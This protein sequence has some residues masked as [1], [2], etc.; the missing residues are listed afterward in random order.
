MKDEV[1]DLEVAVYEGAPV[2]GLLALVGE[3]V[4]HVV[5]V[6]QRPHGLASLD[7]GDGGLRIADGPPCCD[8]PR[9]EARALS[10][11][12]EPDGARI[13]AVQLGQGAH[14][15]GPDGPALVGQHVGDDG[16]LKDAAVEK[17]HDVK[18]GSDD[19]VVLAQPVGLGHRHVGGG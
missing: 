12:L 15:I 2:V 10:E 13:H 4:H 7:V 1:V 11:A 17:L 19:R 3:K 16:V 5:K 8:L 14:G 9:V 6:R 18:G